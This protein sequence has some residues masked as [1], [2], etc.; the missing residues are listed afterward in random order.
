MCQCLSPQPIYNF[1]ISLPHL[2]LGKLI[3]DAPPPTQVITNRKTATGSEIEMFIKLPFK[4][5]VI[6]EVAMYYHPDSGVLFEEVSHSQHSKEGIY[7]SGSHLS[8]LFCFI[9]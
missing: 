1:L 4:L 8:A 9:P 7:L 2:Q 3:L 5:T 6:S